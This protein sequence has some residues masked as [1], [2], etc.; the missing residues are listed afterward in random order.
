MLVYDIKK[1]ERRKD[2]GVDEIQVS[3]MHYWAEEQHSCRR[4]NFLSACF[5]LLGCCVSLAV[6]LRNFVVSHV[7]EEE[8]CDARKKTLFSEATCR[9]LL[10]E[11][12][13]SAASGRRQNF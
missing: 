13:L 10:E 7:A 1:H 11:K 12:P 6:I 9:V 5:G 8:V 3:E 2:F 4:N